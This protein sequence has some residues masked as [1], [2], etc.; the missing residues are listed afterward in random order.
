M[1]TVGRKP[2]PTVLKVLAGNPGK[3][4]IKPEPKPK[5]IA[6]KA[7]TWLPPEAKRRWK[8]LA[9]ELERLG[10]LTCVDGLAFA[11]M[12]THYAMAVEAAKVLKADGVLTKDS[13]NRSRKHPMHQV[14]R[15][16]SEAFR[17]Y[18][19]EFG[20]SPASRA[21]LHLPEVEDDAEDFFSSVTNTKAR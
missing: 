11:M 1:A 5:P 6:P 10:L 16:H 13:K 20:L 14:F 19:S 18:L 12:L 15:D 21:R 2:T 17:Q 4:P 3:R 9:P 7:P 8:E